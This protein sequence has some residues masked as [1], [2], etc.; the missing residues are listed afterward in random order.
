MQQ[1]RLQNKVRFPCRFSSLRA[2]NRE[3]AQTVGDRLAWPHRRTRWVRMISKPVR[4]VPRIG[5]HRPA[6]LTKPRMSPPSS[7]HPRF[8]RNQPNAETDDFSWLTETQSPS[9]GSRSRGT[10]TNGVRLHNAN[11]LEADADVTDS[12]SQRDRSPCLIPLIAVCCV[13]AMVLRADPRA[14]TQPEQF[15]IVCLGERLTKP[16]REPRPEWFDDHRHQRRQPEAERHII[17]AS[18]RITWQP[19]G[20]V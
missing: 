3:R 20:F 7:R 10:G 8:H 19:N 11:S 13:A 17:R 15:Q 18:D 9:H 4:E 12:G 6:L 5:H 14:S 1:H 2:A 16:C